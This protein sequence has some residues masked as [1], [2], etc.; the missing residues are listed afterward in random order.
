MKP[1]TIYLEYKDRRWSA[2]DKNPDLDPA[3]I[4]PFWHAAGETRAEATW[5]LLREM[6]LGNDDRIEIRARTDEWTELGV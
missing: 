2:T 5:N 1:L 4:N 3:D 6:V